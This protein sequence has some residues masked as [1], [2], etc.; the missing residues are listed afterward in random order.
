MNN[1]PLYIWI[2]A[3]FIHSSHLGHSH[4]L[5]I[6]NSAAMNTGIHVSFSIMFSSG[7]IPNGGI[8]RSYGIFIPSFLM[9]LHT[10]HLPWGLCQFTFPPTVQEGSLFFT[11]SP[12][13]VVYRFFDNGPSDRHGFISGLSYSIGLYF[14]FC[15]SWQFK[16]LMWSNSSGFRL[17]NHSDFLGS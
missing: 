2:T 12:A 8:V 10:I 13:F 4:V 14:F 1:I 16:S 17:T 15:A 6:V 7:C 3:F 11:P 5:A 9:N